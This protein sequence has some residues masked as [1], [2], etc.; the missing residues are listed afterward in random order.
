MG[1]ARG[2][3]SK[4][5]LTGVAGVDHPAHEHEGWLVVKERDDLQRALGDAL[6]PAYEVLRDERS[7]L[8]DI[9]RFAEDNQ[10]ALDDLTSMLDGPITKSA[11][12]RTEVERL[13]DDVDALVKWLGDDATQ[14]TTDETLSSVEASRLFWGIA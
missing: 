12:T 10:R 9:A 7:R 11:E 6:R 8:A 3:L 2:F 4:I 14:N 13:V 5:R 1:K